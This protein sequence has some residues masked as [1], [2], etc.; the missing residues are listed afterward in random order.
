MDKNSLIYVAG[1]TGLIGSAIVGMLKRIG[2]H[3][4]I[5]KSHK[6]LD[7]TNQK[8]VTGFFKKYSPSYVF[9]TAGKTGGILANSNY[10]ADF[11]HQNIMI[12]TNIIHSSFIYKVKKLL[13][14]GCACMYPKECLQPIKEEYLLTG[15]IEPTNEPYAIAKISGLK[16]C[17]A[18]NKQYKTNFITAIP[19]NVYGKNDNFNENGH[20]VANLIKRFHEAKANRKKNVTIWGTGNPTRDFIYADDVAEACI[21]LMEKWDCPSFSKKKGTVPFFH[22]NIGSGYEVSIKELAGLVKEVTGFKG[23]ILF[24]KTKPDGMMRKILDT[25]K[26]K[27]LCWK[28]AITLKEGIKLTYNEKDT[29]NFC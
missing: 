1:N 27:E 17:D 2:Y 28:P 23:E 14:L 11:I 9:L 18:Y 7:L 8:K 22:I 3:N 29:K 13:F 21:F 16:M 5:V 20:V 15:K 4:I 12:Q 6:E 25:T 10:P 19:S 24:D 26:M